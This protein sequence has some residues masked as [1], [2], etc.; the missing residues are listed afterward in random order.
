VAW[1]GYAVP[2]EPLAL[3]DLLRGATVAVPTSQKE[4][5]TTA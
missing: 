4:R 5:E 2:A 3:V 1:R